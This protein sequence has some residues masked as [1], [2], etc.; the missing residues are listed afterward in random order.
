[1]KRRRCKKFFIAQNVSLDTIAAQI[2]NNK[3]LPA[4]KIF[5]CQRNSAL[6]SLRGLRTWKIDNQQRNGGYYCQSNTDKPNKRNTHQRIFLVFH[7]RD[8]ESNWN[9]QVHACQTGKDPI[10]TTD[11]DCQVASTVKENRVG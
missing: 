7:A 2:T 8:F 4:T 1:M 5:P 6:Y 3:D 11:F 10:R 9:G